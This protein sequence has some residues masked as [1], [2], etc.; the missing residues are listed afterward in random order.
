MSDD[1]RVATLAVAFA[2]ELAPAILSRL[3][4]PGAEDALRHAA[5]LTAATRRERLLGVA[6]AL[7]PDT[8][9]ARARGDAAR[10]VERPRIAR[11]V[12][13]VGA[14]YP[15]AASVPA[16]LVRVCRERLGR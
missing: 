3:A 16:F 6:A 14:D 11:L 9:A 4:G 12:A 7:E 15:P 1:E 2:K 10:A 5:R 8:A 13:T